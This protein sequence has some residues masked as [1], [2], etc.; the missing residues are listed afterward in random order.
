ML[1]VLGPHPISC[2]R[3]LVVTRG[4]GIVKSPSDDPRFKS[5]QCVLQL[6]GFSFMTPPNSHVLFLLFS[7]S[8]MSDFVTPWT[9]AHQT[10]LSMGFYICQALYVNCISST[11]R[12]FYLKFHPEKSVYSHFSDRNQ[13]QIK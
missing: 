8:L 13:T 5:L 12:T 3:I 1:N 6:L 2:F 11:L 7:S 9:V 4:L 10:P